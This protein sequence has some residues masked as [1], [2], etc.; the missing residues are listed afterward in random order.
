MGAP[1]TGLNGSI[2][3]WIYDL[4]CTVDVSQMAKQEE[5]DAIFTLIGKPILDSSRRS[6]LK[7][8]KDISVNQSP[9]KHNLQQK[10]IAAKDVLPMLDHGTSR[11][12]N[13][14][15]KRVQ[16]NNVIAEPKISK[17]MM[18][19]QMKKRAAKTKML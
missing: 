12:E 4:T 17:T 19:L 10:H 3:D 16:Q 15:E 7:I 9:L 13:E 18:L 1:D 6:K 2:E 5:S 8:L 11:R 14:T